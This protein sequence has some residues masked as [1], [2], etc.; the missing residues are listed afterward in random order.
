[1]GHCITQPA[2]LDALSRTLTSLQIGDS[3]FLARSADFSITDFPQLQRILVGE[4][5][6]IR[7]NNILI[8]HNPALQS[9][10]VRTYAFHKGTGSL[11]LK[12]CPALLR[13]LFHSGACHAFSQGIICGEPLRKP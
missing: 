1:M 7:V 9:V 3:A 10:V 6:C 13:V 11:Q 8:A 4:R 12:D 2:E 5:S